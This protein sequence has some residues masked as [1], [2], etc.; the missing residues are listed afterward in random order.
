MLGNEVKDRLANQNK[1]EVELS[2]RD[3]MVSKENQLVLSKNA[4]EADGNKIEYNSPIEENQ[5]KKNNNNDAAS[6][7][8]ETLKNDDTTLQ[9][10]ESYL[11]KRKIKTEKT[12]LYFCQFCNEKLSKESKYYKGYLI[13]EELLGYDF[14]AINMIKKLI[15]YESLKGVLFNKAQMDGLKMISYP[16]TI[17]ITKEAD[18]KIGELEQC[19][20]KREYGQEELVELSQSF[21]KLKQ[22]NNERDQLILEKIKL[23]MAQ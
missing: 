5:D 19:I 18:E 7:G 16:R 1:A 4:N 6:Q 20:R 14:N 15:E 11:K 13:G 21:N 2:Q 17:D 8:S 9:I 22:S 10:L 12:K 3:E 23:G